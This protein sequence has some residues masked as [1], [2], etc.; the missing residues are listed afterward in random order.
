MPLPNIKPYSGFGAPGTPLPE[1]KDKS[2][3]MSVGG[4]V[5]KAARD[6]VKKE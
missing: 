5:L 4:E 3:L 1:K 2:A 6:A